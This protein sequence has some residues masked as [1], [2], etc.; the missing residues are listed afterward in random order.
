MYLITN[1]G[2][3]FAP[4]SV[5]ETLWPHR[6]YADPKRAVRTMV[7]RLKQVLGEHPPGSGLPQLVLSQGCYSWNAGSR[8][9]LDAEEFERLCREARRLAAERPDQA[10]STYKE[11]LGLYQGDYFPEGAFQEWVIP[12]RHYY[13]RLY[14]Q[15]ALELAGLLRQAREHDTLILFCEKALLIVPFE[16]ELH[17]CFLETLLETGK[18]RQARAHYEYA[19]A[20]LYRELGVKPSPVMRS[21]YS[22]IKS[23]AGDFDPDPSS[24]QQ[25]L[26]AKEE[27]RGVFCCDQ[28]TF[29]HLYQLER[30]RA[31]R[32]GKAAFLGLL[33]F[34]SPRH[35]R[36]HR[37]TL[38]EAMAALQE[39]IRDKLRM[40]DVCCRWNEAQ[41]LLILPGLNL[42]QAEQVLRRVRSGFQEKHPAEDLN[43]LSRV[44]ALLPYWPHDKG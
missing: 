41:Y 12:V 18:V 15:S 3:S 36:T 44:Q 26:E 42:E 17:A 7:C 16:E 39:I 38:R 31:A 10:A 9:W 1:R 37:R 22:L 40:G 29:R 24:V 2:K 8:Y 32:S 34:T 4:E 27:A 35:E 20:A 11:A 21:L 43:L 28:D 14:L 13:A 30:R 33:T 23:Q 5:V 25:T 6:E 19:T